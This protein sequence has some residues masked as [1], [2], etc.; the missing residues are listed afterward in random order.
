MPNTTAQ[1][2]A[3][4]GGPYAQIRTGEVTAASPNGVSVNVSGTTITAGFDKR[5]PV[6]TGELVVLLQQGGTWLVLYALA[7]AGSNQIINPSFTAGLDNWTAYDVSGTTINAQ[8]GPVPGG[9]DGDWYATA[10]TEGAT[11][12]GLLY[13]DP[14]G[15][16]AGDVYSVSAYVWG[17]YTADAVQ[18][19][20][21]AL[22]ALWFANTTNLYPTTSSANTTIASITDVPSAPPFST[23]SGTV[24]APVTGFMRI[25]L[26]SAISS[27]GSLNW[28]LIVAR[29]I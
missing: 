28:D 3:S 23:L 7:G 26:Q 20:D 18:D 9:P 25:G 17:D 4:R 11:A 12:T 15:V 14:I 21:A 5:N 29:E 16:T 10:F 1:T 2:I 27:T 19:A 24:T 22:L 6:Q 13:S 8:V